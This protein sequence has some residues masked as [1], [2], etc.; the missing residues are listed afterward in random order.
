MKFAAFRM[1]ECEESFNIDSEPGDG[2]RYDL[3]VCNDPNGGYLI[4]W[5]SSGEVW[6]GFKD[7]EIKTLSKEVNPYSTKAIQKIWNTFLNEELI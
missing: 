7:G 4:V 2:T 6:R 3:A 5:P 1:C